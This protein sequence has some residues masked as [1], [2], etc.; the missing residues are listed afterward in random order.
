MLVELGC[1][2]SEKRVL[3]KLIVTSSVSGARLQHRLAMRSIAAIIVM[4]K[5]ALTHFADSGRTSREVREVPT[6][7]IPRFLRRLSLRV[8]GHPISLY[9]TGAMPFRAS[10]CPMKRASFAVTVIVNPTQQRQRAPVRAR[11]SLHRSKKLAQLGDSRLS[12]RSWVSRHGS[13]GH[14]RPDRRKPDRRKPGR[15]NRTYS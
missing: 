10:R 11:G 14:R 9:R 2:V 4:P 8:S 15:R 13:Q 12:E 3:K 6:A 1:A 7:D 5:S